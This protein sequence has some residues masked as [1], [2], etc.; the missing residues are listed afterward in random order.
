MEYSKDSF[1]WKMMQLCPNCVTGD[2]FCGECE[3]FYSPPLG[4]MVDSESGSNDSDEIGSGFQDYSPIDSGSEKEGDIEDPEM[5]VYDCSILYK[6]FVE[7]IDDPNMGVYDC[8][9]LYKNEDQE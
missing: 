8:S 9:M 6:K 2:E 3:K 5:G 1:Y 7:D 4:L